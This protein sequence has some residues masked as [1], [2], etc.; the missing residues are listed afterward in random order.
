LIRN[1]ATNAAVWFA[2]R[3]GFVL[4]V[5]DLQDVDIVWKPEDWR[6]FPIVIKEFVVTST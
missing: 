1:A 6:E 4:C 3:I 5:A 2:D